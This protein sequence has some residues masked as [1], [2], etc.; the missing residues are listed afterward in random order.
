MLKDE[1]IKKLQAKNKLW[2]EYF[3][4]IKG[5]MNL[6]PE[7]EKVQMQSDYANNLQV[8]DKIREVEIEKNRIAH[9]LFLLNLRYVRIYA[10]IIHANKEELMWN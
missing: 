1:E 5:Y 8:E 4:I 7:M 6:Q 10:L 3:S 9:K 2:K